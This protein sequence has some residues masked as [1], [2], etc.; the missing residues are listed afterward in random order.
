MNSTR[1][2]IRIFCAALALSSV[3]F[4]GSQSFAGPI[5]GNQVPT[6]RLQIDN[7]PNTWNY[8][9]AVSDYRPATDADG[10]YELTT[11]K[12]FPVL[13]NR[14][15]VRIE[16]LQFYADPFVLNNI[17]VTNTTTST[18]VFTATVA[19][20]TTFPAPNFVSGSVVTSVIDGGGTAG[21]TV[22]TTAGQALYQARIDGSN[23]QTLQNDPFS[24]SS[25]GSASASFGPAVNNTAV[26]SDIS[27]QLRFSLTAGDTAAILS[28]FDV[29]AIPE[30]ASA[31]LI[32][33]GVALVAAIRRRP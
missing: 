1:R 19:L 9:P 26:T 20:P 16:E 12:E 32:G 6:L 25:P 10:G 24:V 27:I 2:S 3:L 5:V 33:I 21:A 7:V 11:P 29:T 14:A 30:P 23:V 17:L 8:S 18:Q 4:A 15:R 31:A 28:R 22:A 13:E